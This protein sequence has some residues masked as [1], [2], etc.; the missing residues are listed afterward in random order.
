M[1]EQENLSTLL[2]NGVGLEPAPPP[3]AVTSNGLSVHYSPTLGKL[4][5]ALSQA[6]LAFKP[7]KKQVE[8]AFYS[9]DRKK[10]MYADLASII[11]ATQKALAEKELV[12]IQFPIT[13][14]E[15]RRAGVV[16]KLI[17]SSGEWCEVELLLPATGRAKRWVDGVQK[18]IEKFD[19]QTIGAAQTYARRYTYGPTVGVSAEEDDDAN[20]IG[21]ASGGSH[22]AQKAVAEK[23]IKAAVDSGKAAALFYAWKDDEQKAYITGDVKLLQDNKELLMFRGKWS[24]KENAFITDAEGLESYKYELNERG[25]PFLQQGAKPLTQQLTE[26]IAQAKAKRQPGE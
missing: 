8:N 12:V 20:S 23:K 26:S 21:E 9:T 13:D 4:A 10:A 24:N 18:E 1:S 25:V 22:E 15:N 11:E 7:I 2:E 5:L 19:A 16:S 14:F 6:Q 17:H 3:A